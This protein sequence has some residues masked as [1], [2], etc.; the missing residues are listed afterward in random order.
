MKKHLRWNSFPLIIFLLF[1]L[2]IN[3]GACVSGC[4]DSRGEEDYYIG[5]TRTEIFHRPCCSYLPS[6]NATHLDTREEAIAAGY[7]PCMHCDP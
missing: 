6:V 4:D 3:S 5:N 7:R 1:L 2:I